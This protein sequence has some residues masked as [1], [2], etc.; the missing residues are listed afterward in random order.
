MAFRVAPW[1]WPVLAVVSP[2]LV[3]WMMSKNHRFKDNREKALRTND[4]KIQAAKP[5]PLPALEQISLTVVCEQEHEQGF[6]SEPGVS[7]LLRSDQGSLLYDIGFGAQYTTFA[8][9]T[10]RLGL[11]M[12]DVDALAISHL[13]ADHMGGLKAQRSRQVTL[14][15]EFG[16]AGA[17]PCYL[18]DTAQAEGFDVQVMTEPQVLKGGLASTG[19]LAR[20]LYFFG[21]TQE[22][23]LVAHVKGKGLFVLTGCGHPTIEVV[24]RMVRQLSDEPIYAIGGGL[25][26]PV[27][28]GRGNYAGFQLQMI[29]GTGKPWWERVT[30][31]DLTNTIRAIQRENPKRLLLSAHDT[32]DHALDRLSREVDAEVEI[33]KAG[34]TYVL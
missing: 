5:L 3:P 28:K 1:W 27:T 21:L 22:Q 15:E 29:V 16:A 12:E 26:F 23:A 7:Y 13:H 18:P 2:A 6:E 20:S 9:N 24:I 30:D 19:P 34:A 11:T 32:C 4:E 33:L 17:K 25:H 14:P 8:K 31:Q 10:S